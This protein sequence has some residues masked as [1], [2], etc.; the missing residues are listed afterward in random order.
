[1]LEGGESGS[2]LKLR[3]QVGQVLSEDC[4]AVTH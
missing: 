4:V 1:L 2:G 3:L